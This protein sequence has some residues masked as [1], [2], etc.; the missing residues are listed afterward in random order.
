MPDRPANTT[1][2]APAALPGAGREAE[3]HLRAWQAQ[4][5][6]LREAAAWGGQLA[7]EGSSP[8][9]RAIGG[10]HQAYALVRLGELAGGERAAIDARALAEAAGD[11]GALIDCRNVQALLL[12]RRQQP[13]DALAVLQHNLA[14]GLAADPAAG[15]FPDAYRRCVSNTLAALSY[16]ELARLDEGLRH[17]LIARDEAERSGDAALLANASANLSGA[18]ADLMNLDDAA[19]LADEAIEAAERAGLRGELIWLTASFNRCYIALSAGDTVRAQEIALGMRATASAVPSAKQARY[20]LLWAKA[21][22]A[23][24]DLL[25]AA[26]LLARSRRRWASGDDLLLEWSVARAALDNAAGRRAGDGG[27]PAKALLRHV[28]AR[29]VCDAACGLTT[30]GGEEALPLDR[31]HLFEQGSL[32]CEAL[33]DPGAALAYARRA[34]AQYEQVA[35]RSARARRVT[36]EAHLALQ[37]ERRSREEAVRRRQAAEEEKRRLTELNAALLQANQAKTRFLAAASHDLRQPMHALMLQSANLR[38]ALNDPD[39]TAAPLIADRLQHSVQALS[40]MFDALL[41]ISLVE[42][43]SMPTHRGPVAPRGLLLRL[44]EELQ[45]QAEQ[46]GLRL[47]LRL[48]PGSASLRLDTDAALLETMLRNLLANALKYTPR[49]GVMLALRRHH[50][51]PGQWRV[52]VIDTGLGIDPAWQQ[53]VFEDFVQVHNPGR[54]RSLGLGLGLAIVRRLATLLAHPLSLR[55]QPG[56]GTCVSLQLT[57]AQLPTG[58]AAPDTQAPVPLPMAGGRVA[59]VEDDPDAL[60]AMVDLLHGWQIQTL[61]ADRAEVLLQ[62]LAGSDGRPGPAIDALI[63]D[64]R[65]PGA[66][67]GLALVQALRSQ[68][69]FSGLPALVVTADLARPR[70]PLVD[71]LGKPVGAQALNDWLQRHL[72]ALRAGTPRRG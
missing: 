11:A 62:A 20:A 60:Q 72:P 36:E 12:R 23:S 35:G 55:S 43:G 21:A 26:R 18:Q 67:D 59:I 32:A 66:L 41:D 31:M 50:R 48:P 71:W 39:R 69:R 40:G 70:S 34:F 49:G 52:Q 16:S 9:W 3:L 29:A 17:Y 64:L 6:N 19:P 8:A 65:L 28:R 22:V 2:F 58:A 4:Y 46:Q 51:Q 25:D 44:V 56:R 14:P 53:K 45:P 37:L 57:E 1:H 38:A 5:R 15:A 63:T 33:G 27:R 30:S 7:A 54:Q 13:R 42:S 24:G 10:C 68:T 47:V 61:A